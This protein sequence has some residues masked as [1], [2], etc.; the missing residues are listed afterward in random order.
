MVIAR[1]LL[2]DIELFTPA[3]LLASL[4]GGEGWTVAGLAAA[5]WFLIFALMPLFN[6]DGL[7][8]GD[9]VAGSWVVE[10]PRRRLEPAMSLQ[11]DGEAEARSP[12]LFSDAELSV[13][14]E[15]ELQTLERLLREDRADALEAVH[16]TVAGKIGREAH[17]GQER[18][19]LEAYYGQL[20]ARLEAGLRMGR[21]KT[22][23]FD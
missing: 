21:R 19:F 2:R 1:N 4:G 17:W 7:R 12:F 13:Y 20:R 16:R 18:A 8:A 15:Y 10:A 6:R 22:D 3:V 23:K 14:G 11:P 5:A 9:I